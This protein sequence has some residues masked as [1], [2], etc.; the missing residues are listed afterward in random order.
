MKISVESSAL[1]VRRTGVGQYLYG[2]M[3][4]V[5]KLDNVNQYKLVAFLFLGKSVELPL[6]GFTYKF[7]RYI[8]GRVYNW[9]FFHHL[10]PPI[11]LLVGKPDIFFFPNFTIWPL[12]RTKK[13]VVVIYDLS[14]VLQAQHSQWDKL[15]GAQVPKS[16]SRASRVV[17]ISENSK[18]EIVQHYKTDPAKISIVY[19]AVDHGRFLPGPR[20]DAVLGKYKISGKYILY[21]GTLEPRKNI[22]GLLEAYATLPDP[23]RAAY[24]LVLAGGKGW[25]DDAIEAKL[26]QLSGLP[27]IRTGYIPDEDLPELYRGASLFVYPSHYEGFGMPPLEAM[28]SGV[29]VITSNNSSLPEVV[30][31][32]GIMVDSNDTSALTTAIEDVLANPKQMTDMRQLGLAQAQKFNWEA[33]AQKLVEVFEQVGEQA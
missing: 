4:A 15:L 21:T 26:A 14:F 1:F 12:A 17:T 16:V 32:A 6:P 7:V 13:S 22:V 8:P 27:I 3:Q 33:S 11:D 18:R 29:P 2:L 31:N 19:P 5:S 20:N 28:A 24:S 30:G 23:V 25:L 9:L 10:A